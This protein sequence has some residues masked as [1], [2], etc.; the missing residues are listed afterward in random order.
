MDK[1]EERVWFKFFEMNPAHCFCVF[2]SLASLRGSLHSSSEV[3]QDEEQWMPIKEYGFVN[4]V[5]E[6]F[7]PVN[8]TLHLRHRDGAIK[9][10]RC[11]LVTAV[12]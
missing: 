7:F 5:S 3:Y 11:C 1:I 12:Y 2:P 9:P 6:V 4:Q 8:L 10:S